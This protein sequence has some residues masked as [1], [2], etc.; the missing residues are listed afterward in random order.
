MAAFRP[1]RLSSRFKFIALDNK[2]KIKI[3]NWNRKLLTVRR[4]VWWCWIRIQN[5]RRRRPPS[6]SWDCKVPAEK[7]D[8]RATWCLRS[9]WTRPFTTYLAARS[10]SLPIIITS[11][12]CQY[13]TVSST[14]CLMKTRWAI[15][16]LSSKAKVKLDL[17]TIKVRRLS[18]RNGE[19]RQL[20]IWRATRTII[21]I[22]S[23]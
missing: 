20:N 10:M 12:K 21:S 2:N 11:R 18:I 14:A 19:T 13:R 7:A 23:H 15:M 22:N 17:P 1:S 6:T 4:T 3:N 8:R 5:S 9:L 16:R